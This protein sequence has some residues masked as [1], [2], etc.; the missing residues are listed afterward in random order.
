[1]RTKSV[2]KNTINVIT[3]GC[4]KN[5]YDS[6][7]L[8]GHLRANGKQ[9]EHE[10]SGNIVVVNTCGFIDSAK[11]ESLDAIGEALNENGKVIVT[12]CMGKDA[13]EI[14]R[15]HPGV[16]A[17]TGEHVEAVDEK[18]AGLRVT[19]HRGEGVDAG[20]GGAA[21]SGGEVCG[22]LDR[23]G[24]VRA[25][26]ASR[27]RSMRSTRACRSARPASLPGSSREY[28]K[29]FY[30]YAKYIPVTRG[31]TFS[32]HGDLGYG[33]ACH[34]LADALREEE[35]LPP[36]TEEP[37]PPD[38]LAPAIH[39]FLARTPCALLGI[40]LDEATT[41]NDVET[42]LGRRRYVPEL[43][44]RNWNIR[45]FGE[46]IAQNTPIQGTAADLIKQAMLDVAGALE[47]GGGKARM[48]LQV[49]D[50]LVFHITHLDDVHV[51][52]D[53]VGHH[54]RPDRFVR[55]LDAVH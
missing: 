50:E 5:L 38:E 9:V 39:R 25:P 51:H 49:H 53:P 44:S 55:G 14:T 6:E 10:G 35:V 18:L 32:F 8:M 30:R 2:K 47:T 27:V 36:D 41:E 7:V 48:I 24:G 54:D 26:P 43:K 34:A 15:V 4:S 19:V 22:A 52:V 23:G 45:Q 29:L 12:G 11:R 31:L 20:A 33:D 13:E 28:Y 1:M 46:R 42:L 17:V 40:S 21:G 37:P 16:L 3:L